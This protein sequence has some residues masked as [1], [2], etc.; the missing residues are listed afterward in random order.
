MNPKVVFVER[1][2]R[3][4]SSSIAR[5]FTV[6]GQILRARG[7]DLERKKLPYGNSWKGMIANIF[8]KRPSDADVFHVTGHANYYA[9]LLPRDKT[10]LTIHDLQV[11]NDRNGIRKFFVKRFFYDLPVRRVKYITVISEHVKDDLIRATGCDQEKLVVIDNPITVSP[12]EHEKPFND[13]CPTILHVGTARHKNL[14][15]LI[16]ALGGMKCCLKVIGPLDPETVEMLRQRSIKF[17][18]RS[19]IS[20]EEILEEYRR[21]DIVSFCTV[22]EGFGLPILEAQSLSIPLIT[23]NLPPMNEVAGSGAILV[24]PYNPEKIRDGILKIIR[25]AKTRSEIV[26][27]GRENIKR[28]EPERIASEYQDLYSKVVSDNRDGRANN[29][30]TI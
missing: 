1:S 28:F 13:Q 15:N 23:S 16:E 17:E 25:D 27:K 10:I 11:L 21:S 18:N 26:I 14:P 2:D 22:A 29:Q 5:V 30:A 3:E 19:G 4:T 7:I 20:D 9:L 24:D 8:A 6:V 12:E